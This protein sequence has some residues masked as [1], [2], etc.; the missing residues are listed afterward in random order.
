VHLILKAPQCSTHLVHGPRWY[1]HR[2]PQELDHGPA[3]DPVLIQ[4]P[5][6]LL[7]AQVRALLSDWVLV[8]HGVRSLLGEEG[9][10]G[11]RGELDFTTRAF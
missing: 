4:Q 10:E 11:G 7:P 1:E 8:Q 6:P 2:V 9:G 3:L 5:L